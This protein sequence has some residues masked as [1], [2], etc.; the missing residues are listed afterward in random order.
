M[1]D[2]RTRMRI[3]GPPEDDRVLFLELA[4][5]IPVSPERL[6]FVPAL[7]AEGAPRTTIGILVYH[8]SVPVIDYRYLS[9][10]ETLVLNWDDPWYTAFENRNLTRHHKWPQMSFIYIE[11][12]EV[13]Q[14]ILVRVRDLMAWTKEWP[15]LQVQLSDKD[16]A[17]LKNMARDYF[18]TRNPL[19]IDGIETPVSSFR[20]EYLNI[21]PTGLKV[22]E[23]DMPVDASA[24]ILG[25]SHSY[26]TETIP[27]TVSVEWQLFDERV[28]QVPTNVIDPAGPFPGF[29]T[30]DRPHIEWQNFLKKYNEPEI[31]VVEVGDGSLFDF[32]AIRR[33]FRGTPDDEI[34]MIIVQ[35]LL[36]NAAAGFLVRDP[37]A[38][39]ATLLNFIMSERLVDVR[40]E[41]ARAFATPTKGGGVASVDAIYDL[42]LT[43]I[44]E[45]NDLPGFGVLAVWTAKAIGRHWG[46]VDSRELRFRAQIDIVEI[47]N[48]WKFQGLTLIDVRQIDP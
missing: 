47:D 7:D 34:A 25:I 45:L 19:S 16:Q 14:E 13:R 28:D 32:S 41:L 40:T 10:A 8:K 15:E 5:D 46:H 6:T 30:V 44:N 9:Q 22:V 43:N 12:R 26:W 33:A 42:E 11:P 4:Y 2:P 20:A 37:L 3:P 24:A 35:R 29:I 17:R 1:I 31:K 38:L 23:S 27:E 18:A 21:S 39:D 48:Q 36:E